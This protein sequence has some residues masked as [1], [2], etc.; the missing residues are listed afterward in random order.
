MLSIEVKGLQPF[1][2]T[3]HEAR[4]TET[5]RPMPAGEEITRFIRASFR[6]LWAL[7][8]LLHLKASRDRAWL[9]EDLVMALRGSSLIVEQSLDG[10]MRAGLV[11]IDRDGRAQFLP[12]TPDLERLTDQ[13]EE[14]YRRRPDTVRR[15][16]VSGTHPGL[17]NFA[18][19]FKL[20]ED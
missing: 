14:L 4:V 5:G 9:T 7:E 3:L 6:S 10:L 19:A 16:I 15:I 18:D 12:A 8:L 2:G 20:W 11:T 17:A 13:V 1:D